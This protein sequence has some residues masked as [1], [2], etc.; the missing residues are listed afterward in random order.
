MSRG[1]R[2][3]LDWRCSESDVKVL[4]RGHEERVGDDGVGVGRLAPLSGV[5]LSRQQEHLQHA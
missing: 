4:G 5:G 3:A 1:A 2:G